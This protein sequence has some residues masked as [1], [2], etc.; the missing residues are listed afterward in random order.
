LSAWR[1]L[2]ELSGSSV[3]VGVLWPGD[4]KFLPVLDYP[5]EGEDI[6]FA[7]D[8]NRFCLL[9]GGRLLIVQRQKMKTRII[10]MKRV[11][12][13]IAGI[14]RALKSDKASF[15]NSFSEEYVRRKEEIY[16]KLSR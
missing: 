9:Y 12:A 6:S 8:G 3:Y 15:E 16:A 5:V 14:Y 4:S 10:E 7:P 1:H 13:Q 2:L 11:A